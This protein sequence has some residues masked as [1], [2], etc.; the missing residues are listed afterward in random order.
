MGISISAVGNGKITAIAAGTS[1]DGSFTVDG[2]RALSLTTAGPVS[3]SY[4][5]GGIGSAGASL[6]ISKSG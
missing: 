3:A 2:N 4:G 6:R 1:E 5:K